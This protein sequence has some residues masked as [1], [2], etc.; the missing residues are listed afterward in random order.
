M[1]T[2]FAI[3]AETSKIIITIAVVG[4]AL[5]AMKI[6]Q[7]PIKRMRESSNG[8]RGAGTVVKSTILIAIWGWVIC[9]VLDIWFDIDVAGIVGALGVVG[10]AISLGAQQTIANLIG[11]VIISL[12]NMVGP[13]D[14]V[15]LAN[16][17]EARV[18]DTNWRRTTLEDEEGVQFAVP[19]STMVSSIVRVEQ[20]FRIINVP[21]A[22]HVTTT[23]LKELLADCE[24]AVL[25][26][27]IAE[28]LDY[29]GKRPKAHLIGSS[30]GHMK[31]EMLV[32]TNR[33]LDSRNTERLVLPALFDLL[34]E[35]NA[36]PSFGPPS[37][38]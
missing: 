13:N 30:M 17:K 35:R 20:P 23:N 22:L 15:C 32:Y 16:H 28:G 29:E 24:Q 8:R 1:E 3:S 11:G 10:I 31:V 27:L 33:T 7:I 25:D 12:S 5:I 4:I 18:I 19:N 6:L 21:F 9:E 14:W 34:Q 38:K 37:G 2:G 26:G 36:M